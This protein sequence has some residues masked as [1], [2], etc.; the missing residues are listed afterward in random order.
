MALFNIAPASL[1]APES[2]LMAPVSD[3]P[4]ER[5]I[6]TKQSDDPFAGWETV[7]ESDDPFAGWESVDKSFMEHTKEAYQGAVSGL[8]KRATQLGDTEEAKKQAGREMAQG[9]V[10]SFV[11]QLTSFV[12]R[13]GNASDVYLLRNMYKWM[14][15]NKEDLSPEEVRQKLQE[16]PF[17]DKLQAGLR[18]VLGYTDETKSAFVGGQEL[19]GVPFA[20]VMG[21]VG[22]VAG[23]V[24]QLIAEGVLRAAG[25]AGAGAGRRAPK[26]T[27]T[28]LA[29]HTRGQFV[30]PPEAPRPQSFYDQFQGPL[31]RDQQ[32][33]GPEPLP[34]FG[35]PEQG[36]LFGVDPR[37]Q[38]PAGP[39]KPEQVLR[40]QA[41]TIQDPQRTILGDTM[42][43]PPR[44]MSDVN[45]TLTEQTSIFDQ[46][47]GQGTPEMP[48]SRS[49]RQERQAQAQFEEAVAMHRANK[50]QDEARESQARMSEEQRQDL[51]K[52]AEIEHAYRERDASDAEFRRMSEEAAYRQRALDEDPPYTT[53][54]LIDYDFEQRRV[55]HFE[56]AYLEFAQ[57][58]IDKA[59][60]EFERAAQARAAARQSKRLRSE[61]KL[62]MMDGTEIL[63][64]L[65]RM[66]TDWKGVF[67]PVAI[68]KALQE[69]KD[70]TARIAFIKPIEYR[71]YA[72]QME[73]GEFYPQ[74]YD[75]IRAALDNG[76]LD[77]IPTLDVEKIGEHWTVVNHD[78]RHR[79]DVFLERGKGPMPVLVRDV[80]DTQS[81]WSEN[82]TALRGQDMQTILRNPAARVHGGGVLTMG[83]DPAKFTES[84]RTAWAN[85]KGAQQESGPRAGKFEEL[86]GLPSMSTE[87]FIKHLASAE[88][89]PGDTRVQVGLA[90]ASYRA[91]NQA[92]RN[93]KSLAH[94]VLLHFDHRIRNIFRYEQEL[95]ANIREK[96]HDFSDHYKA[97]ALLKRNA[98]VEEFRNDLRIALSF[99]KDPQSWGGGPG[100]WYPSLDDLMNRGM[101]VEAAKVWRG[102]FDMMEQTFNVLEATITKAGVKM[103]ARVPGYLPHVF[104]GPYRLVIAE[105][106]T[107]VPNPSYV[108]EM[109]FYNMRD[110]EKTKA[111]LE[112][113]FKD[114]NYSY[115]IERPTAWGN[116]ASDLLNGLYRASSIQAAAR[117]T[118]NLMKTI[119]ESNAKG[120]IGSALERQK[121]PKWGHTLDR[122]VSA[123]PVMQLPRGRIVDAM[124]SLHKS[125]EAVNAWSARVR[126]VSETL[127]PLEQG[128][129]L[130]PGTNLH[131][132]VHRYMEA[133]MKI[134]N[135]IF[136]ELDAKT[137]DIL[138][139]QG[140]DPSLAHTVMEHINSGFAKYFLFG[141]IPFYVVNALQ[142]TVAL[143]NLA[144]KK[145]MQQLA[146]ERT[147]SISKAL[148][149]AT[150]DIYDGW[151][152][153]TIERRFNS[154]VMKWAYDQGYLNPVLVEYM[155]NARFSDPVALKIDQK[156]RWTAFAINYHYYKQM[157]PEM[158]ARRL[159][160]EATNE[161]AVPYSHQVGAPLVLG[162]VP[163]IGRPMV[164][165]AT[166]MMHMFGMMNQQ[167]IVMQRAAVNKN[168]K[169]FA[170][171]LASAAGLQTM[172][173]M[174]YG[175][176]GLALYQNWND[177]IMFL[178][179]TMGTTFKTSEEVGREWDKKLGTDGLLTYGLVSKLLGY[180]ISSSAQGVAYQ[181]PLAGVTAFGSGITAGFL[182]GKWALNKAGVID[183]QIT[184]KEVWE[185]ARSMPAFWRG[186]VEWLL[187]SNILS[188]EKIPTQGVAGDF[189]TMVTSDVN[190]PGP[191]RGGTDPTDQWGDMLMRVLFGPVSMEE[192]QFGATERINKYRQARNAQR[193]ANLAQRFREQGATDE[194]VQE[195]TKL[196]QDLGYNPDAL[197]RAMVRYQLLR[198]LTPMERKMLQL[199]N[200]PAGILKLQQYQD[201][202]AEEEP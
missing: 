171:A 115:E 2:D 64:A 10:W 194:N 169:A 143:P 145:S 76:G 32:F 12:E 100:K 167:R 195:A 140:L 8:Q 47:A 110:L 197:L 21:K 153:L 119:Y 1:L 150:K 69:V 4:S 184:K 176:G 23:P 155:D 50:M 14:S 74:R 55:S 22:D 133:Y 190:L 36:D 135:P 189:A 199:G 118:S 129:Y 128:G 35:V 57:R 170:N 201:L 187:R 71:R 93:P 141:N 192:K 131:K 38:T 99:E 196:A 161:V 29:D 114:K 70:G 156:T 127:F 183:R 96:F 37:Y 58:N 186:K 134:P 139:A 116:E 163:V 102:V 6:T 79:S 89:L 72:A 125:A 90:S 95:N 107:N 11:G 66:A 165:F 97:T 86:A 123:D 132:S 159:A 73:Q 101:S 41:H 174:L 136:K 175:L 160:G 5:P 177:I 137:R 173:V 39:P 62:G 88:L 146:G 166:Y 200:T 51:L 63:E 172:N 126:F 52:Q 44:G 18:S 46:A 117:Q 121:V 60:G 65:R 81:F 191:R 13:V 20:G 147:G 198:Q 180:D 26:P 80:S 78:G 9:A 24:G 158:T 108:G 103:P 54:D 179:Q 83:V 67:Q 142:S 92:L 34:G 42:P 98:K 85:W 87:T 112:A 27:Q 45:P 124:T 162:K 43:P 148:K 25:F 104:S 3:M 94:Q 138:I 109:G 120:I 91:V 84:M 144:L 15:D 33:V 16:T 48:L 164:M 75:A 130:Q 181:A 61:G 53:Q 202:Q 19:V 182:A 59:T 28:P 30:G 7:K 56:Q 17:S 68:R 82:P 151:S 178:N 113:R 122:V 193:T 154:P 111:I 152:V 105:G 157:H 188:P 149:D 40:E 168:P 77:A 31:P 106:P 49:A 185:T